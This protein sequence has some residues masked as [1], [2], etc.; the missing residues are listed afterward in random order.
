MEPTLGAEYL[1]TSDLPIYRGTCSNLSRVDGA[2][3]IE[4]LKTIL[5]EIGPTCGFSQVSPKLRK[6]LGCLAKK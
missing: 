3:P 1:E 6:N 4:P 2:S 5:D